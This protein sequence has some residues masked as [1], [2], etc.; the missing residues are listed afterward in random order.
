MRRPRDGCLWCEKR[1]KKK[2]MLKKRPLR[3]GKLIVR[4]SQTNPGRKQH[5]G[6]RSN[7]KNSGRRPED[8]EKRGKKGGVR[9][10]TKYSDLRKK[11]KKRSGK[12]DKK[13][14]GKSG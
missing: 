11:K 5:P 7:G 13:T 3:G 4:V 2:K 10:G 9:V 8:C 12:K 1:R 14:L 6:K